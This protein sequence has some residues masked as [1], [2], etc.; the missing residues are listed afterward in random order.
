MKQLLLIVSMA[1]FPFSLQANQAE[2]TT[3]TAV[4]VQQPPRQVKIQTEFDESELKALGLQPSALLSEIT[5]RLALG[6][7]Q[8][9]NDI[10]APVLALRI[11]SIEQDKLVAAFVQLAFF[12]KATLLRNNS[13]IM[14]QTWSKAAMLGGS[15]ESIAKEVTDSV[16]SM[17]TTFILDYQ[18]ALSS[19]S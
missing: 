19:L 18:K 1:C 6:Q 16:T 15:K 7:I 2:Y 3:S 4:P 11:K 10:E 9:K 5:T 13:L 12:E 8:I 14:A 17:V